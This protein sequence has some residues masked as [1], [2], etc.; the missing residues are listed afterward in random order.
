MVSLQI[1]AKIQ[2]K[3]RINQSNA[4]G[5]CAGAH[6]CSTSSSTLRACVIAGNTSEKN[7]E[8]RDSIPAEQPD[9]M[10]DS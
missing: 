6:E 4:I 3:P 10:R 1:D 9:G 2:A 5:G 7:G 8:N